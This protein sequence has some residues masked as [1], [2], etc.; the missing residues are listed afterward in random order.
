MKNK[1]LIIDGHNLLFQMFFGMPARIVNKDGIAIQ[2]VLGFV[3][4]LNKIIS[5]IE[6]T[7]IVVL[8]DSE[9]H[10][11]RKD[12]VEEYKANRIDYTDVPE[13][14]N[15][16]SQLPYV[17]KALDFMKIKHTEVIGY[18]TDDV[19]ASY[20]IRYSRKISCLISSWDS[21][22]FQLINESVN[23]LRYRGKKTMLC[24]VDF[25]QNKFEIAPVHSSC[26]LTG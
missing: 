2:G 18:E 16:F 19:I 22:Y 7:Y 14:E 21:D 13:E 12:I 11:D 17:Y 6:P 9:Q 8:F 25:I 3:G 23:V 15:P 26:C 4:A 24:D 10:N 1:L 20:V 5:M